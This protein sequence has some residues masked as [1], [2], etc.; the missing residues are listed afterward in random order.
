MCGIAGE[1]RFDGRRPDTG[2]VD[3]MAITLEH[4]GPDGHGSWSDN[5]T[6]LAHRRLAIRDLG[7]T[8]A[9]P[10]LSPDGQVVVSFNGE[11]YNYAELRTELERFFGCVFR[12]SCDAEILPTGYAVWGEALFPRLEGMFA[13]A[14]WDA[15]KQRLYL[16][17]DG[18]GIKPLY[19]R[20]AQRRVL[21]GSELKAITAA[22]GL[23]G[24]LDPKALHTY[25][26]QGFVGPETT[27]IPDVR[28][29]PPGS[30]LRFSVEGVETRRF[31]TPT[32]V[33]DITDADVA[34]ER[35][36]AL[37]SRVCRDMLVSDVPV[38]I[39]QSAGVD[40]S[41][42]SLTLAD[43][44]I[45]LYTGRFSR[46]DFDESSAA[47]EVAGRIGAPWQTVLCD[48][49]G[50]LEEDL[51]R[52]IWHFDG[53]VADSSGLAYFRLTRQM[54]RHV[55]V[56]LSGDGADE[57]FAGYDTYCASRL[58]ARYGHWIP[59]RL[60]DRMAALAFAAGS[61]SPE[62]YPWRQLL[63]RFLLG[64]RA[65]SL[66]HAEWRRYVMPWDCERLYAGPMRALLREDP[67]SEYK[68]A[69]TGR[70][71]LLDR[72]LLADQTYYLPGDMLMKADAMSMAHGLEVRVPFLDR[73]IMDFA[74]RLAPSLLGGNCR[75]RP[76]SFLRA[77]LARH[78]APPAIV[79][80]K[81]TGFN[82]PAA[83]ML[84][85]QLHG[86]AQRVFEQR[87]EAFSPY[88]DP[89]AVRV[90]WREHR[91]GKRDHGYALWALLTLSIWW[92]Q[93]A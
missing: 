52:V 19:Y 78:G 46:E 64:L 22:V 61:R 32:R 86:L 36:A 58:A 73:R 27:L 10:I 16:V 26:A 47:R 77:A 35:F 24:S 25:L 62:R 18:V 7:P 91:D 44:S 5:T 59:G 54:R 92:R 80:R 39:L 38:G 65:R 70:S 42:I 23:P 83:A 37:F 72:C 30:W 49:G 57:F 12:G 11:I 76:K 79:A 6:A 55:T 74:G 15:R 68:D 85:G 48:T 89:Q 31:W 90:F 33:A 69:I 75:A 13:I 93:A 53:Q 28:Q 88:L 51:T 21:F 63:G 14:L 41:L 40:S 2:L 81:K 1:S 82:V 67:L 84:R 50:E 3:R 8:G 17:R 71:E 34:L 45:P 20:W 60:A 43:P 66:A 9:Q 87:A 56:A 29:V 4:R